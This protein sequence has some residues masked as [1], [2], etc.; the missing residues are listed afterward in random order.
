MVRRESILKL[1]GIAG[2]AGALRW[3]PV[4]ASPPFRLCGFL[5]LTNRPCPLCGLTRAVF[6]LAK[7]E[8]T[9]ALHWNAL[10]PLAVAMLLSLCWGGRLRGPL[11]QAG[12]AAFAVY[13]LVRIWAPWV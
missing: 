11:W 9:A 13:G 6:A 4:P 10:S 12:L 3:I 5:W 2:L 8:W 1:A 7:G